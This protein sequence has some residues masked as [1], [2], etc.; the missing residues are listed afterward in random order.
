[1]KLSGRLVSPPPP[2]AAKRAESPS[3]ILSP[4]PIPIP[5]IPTAPL[6]AF[7]AAFEDSIQLSPSESAFSH[8]GEVIPPPPFPF[9]AGLAVPAVPPLAFMVEELVERARN[10]GNGAVDCGMTSS[11]SE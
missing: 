2:A 6:A 4:T 10:D 7:S 5:A 1:M 3:L 8:A 9:V 11:R